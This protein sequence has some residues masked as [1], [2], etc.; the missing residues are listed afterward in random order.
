MLAHVLAATDPEA[1]SV[2]AR[3]ASGGAM[4]GSEGAR[5]PRGGPALPRSQ[6]SGAPDGSPEPPAWVARL[7]ASQGP[8]ANG[9]PGGPWKAPC[10]AVANPRFLGRNRG[11][12]AVQGQPEGPGG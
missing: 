11:V 6:P 4:R 3:R 12:R 9:R 10:G 8:P 7:R 5:S 1:G 2:A